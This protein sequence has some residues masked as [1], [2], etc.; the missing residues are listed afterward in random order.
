[1]RNAETVLEVIRERG[2]KGLPLERVYRL[3][4]N[5]ELHLVAYGRIAT[6]DGALTPGTT[7]ETADGMS[8]ARIDAIIEALRIEPLPTRS[9]T[10]SNTAP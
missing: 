4:F 6:N 9:D 3:L 5:P 7:P 10:H 1:M 2:T 8:R